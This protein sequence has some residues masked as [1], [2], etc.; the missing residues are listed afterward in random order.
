M[1][2][3]IEAHHVLSEVKHW[4]KSART[5]KE[6]KFGNRLRFVVLYGCEAWSLTLREDRR[7]RVFENSVL[8]IVFGARGDQVTKNGGNYIM[9]SLVICILY[10]ILC[11]R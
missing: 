3:I 9:K 5:G 4:K 1:V 2:F 11:G 7:L 8:R 10:G 6:I